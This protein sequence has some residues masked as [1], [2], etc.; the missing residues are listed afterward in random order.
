MLRPR[1]AP[2]RSTD[3]GTIQGLFGSG[4]ATEALSEIILEPVEARNQKD[5]LTMPTSTFKDGCFY[6]AESDQ[7]DRTER[8][9]D[10]TGEMTLR[11]ALLHAISF[12][13]SG[14]EGYEDTEVSPGDCIRIS[15]PYPIGRI[16]TV[17]TIT[18]KDLDDAD[19]L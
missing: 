15:G 17:F 13:S 2:A 9:T 5:T 12:F 19:D 14:A 4:D 1:R 8:V 6:V 3:D 10:S 11:D 18:Q 16:S 7:F